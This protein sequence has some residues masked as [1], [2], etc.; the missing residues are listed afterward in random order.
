M[1]QTNTAVFRSASSTGNAWWKPLA[2]LGRPAV[3]AGGYYVGCLA[4]FALLFPGSGISFFW[5]PT[6]VLT[7]ALLLNAPRS[8]FGMLAAAFFAHAIAHAQRGVPTAASPILFFGNA[9][10]AVLAAATVRHFL[11][12]SSLFANPRNVTAFVIGACALAPAHGICHRRVCA[13]TGTRLG[14]SLLRLRAT[15][16]GA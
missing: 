11:R 15:G 2:A 13:G 1:L 8:W 16:L 4:G 12:G 3:V 7:A 14:G 5:P 6:A 10:Q 9:S